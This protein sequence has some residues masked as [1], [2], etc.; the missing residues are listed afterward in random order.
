[1]RTG[2]WKGTLAERAHLEDLG[3][4]W[5]GNIEIYLKLVG[6]AYIGLIRLKMGSSG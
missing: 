6:K 2:V 5:E 1:M 4:G 3:I